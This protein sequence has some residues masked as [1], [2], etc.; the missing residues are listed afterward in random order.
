M[1][2]ILA[3]SV[4]AALTQ[5]GTINTFLGEEQATAW[6]K[7]DLYTTFTTDASLFTWDGSKLTPYKDITATLKVDSDRNKIKINAK[8]GLPL[9]GKVDAE[10]LVDL[11]QGKAFEYV[12]FLGLCQKTPLNAT[13]NLKD[14]L[15]KVYSPD[16]GVTTYDGEASA[17]W[18]KSTMYKFHGAGPDATV[19][20]WFDE[21]THNGKWIFEDAKNATVPD[22]V[23]SI[24][25]GEQ[26]ATFTDA[27]FVIKGCSSYN[28]DPSTRVN[29]WRD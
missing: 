22:I 19:S 2:K 28:E 12:P 11:T 27:D 13:V 29:L 18:D 24:P 15:Q 14:V 17:P 8:V 6:P 23:A 26:Q 9:V 1:F 25:K 7:L 3:L 21:S 16:G 4:F 10:V 20:A 5:C